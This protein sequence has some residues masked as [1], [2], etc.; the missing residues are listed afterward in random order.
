MLEGPGVHRQPNN[1][2]LQVLHWLQSTQNRVLLVAKKVVQPVA[3][4][5]RAGISQQEKLLRS[6]TNNTAT[7]WSCRM[8]S[9]LLTH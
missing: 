3:Q 5:V 1:G 2:F 8:Y 4:W 9:N 6:E 7:A